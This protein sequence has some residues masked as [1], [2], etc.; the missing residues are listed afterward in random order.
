[1]SSKLPMELL[2][3]ITEE[4]KCLKCYVKWCKALNFEDKK[5]TDPFNPL[6]WK[7]CQHCTKEFMKENDNM[8]ENEIKKLRGRGAPIYLPTRRRIN[9]NKI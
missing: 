4:I 1:M 9:F 6:F 5:S 2:L 3:M 8:W 7:V